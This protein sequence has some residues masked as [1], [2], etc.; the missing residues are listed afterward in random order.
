MAKTIQEERLRWVLPIV[1]GEVK[2]CNVAKVCPH[3]KRT[4][5]RWVALYRQGGADELVPKSTRPKTHP[6][7][8]PI[9]IKEQVIALR[10]ETKL[11]ALKLKWR[12]A[13]NNISLHE[14]TV[15]K[16][17]KALIAAE[18]IGD[19]K[20]FIA[21]ATAYAKDRELFGRPIGQNQGVQFPI[22]RAYAQMR[23]AELMVRDAAAR[24]RGGASAPVAGTSASGAARTRAVDA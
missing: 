2:L 6:E 16:I 11:C 23:A 8:T 22:A 24:C 13:K 10:K 14:R 20:W 3:S 19:A 4:L 7:E 9:H 15:G 5:E 21:R 18:C 12:L 17:I 1:R